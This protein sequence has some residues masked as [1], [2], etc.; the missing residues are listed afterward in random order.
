MAADL[1]AAVDDDSA[2]APVL[3]DDSDDPLAA[4]VDEEGQLLDLLEEP[5][6]GREEE[7]EG[8]R[9]EELSPRPAENEEWSA[10]PELVLLGLLELQRGLDKGLLASLG[11]SFLGI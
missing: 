10:R 3:V 5:E 7:P 11:E 6:E 1:T 9:E 8:E 4:A 2:V